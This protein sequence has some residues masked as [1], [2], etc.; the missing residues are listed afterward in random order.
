MTIVFPDTPKFLGQKQIAITFSKRLLVLLLN[1]AA[2]CTNYRGFYIYKKTHQT[3]QKESFY[4][5]KRVKMFVFVRKKTRFC[6]TGEATTYK[7]SLCT[8]YQSKQTR[9]LAK[10]SR[11]DG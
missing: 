8:N 10:T 4:K 5:F 2:N 9:C 3:G 6:R 7:L 11:S 1:G